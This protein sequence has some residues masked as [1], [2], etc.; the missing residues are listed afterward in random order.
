M[1]IRDRGMSAN[2]SIGEEE[3]DIS[4]KEM[5]LS[6]TIGIVL[7]VGLFVVLPLFAIGSVRDWFPNSSAFVAA[8][9]VMRI[10]ILVIYITVVS[11]IKQM[12]RV[13]EYHGAEHKTIHALESG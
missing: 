11:R 4:K 9:G 10:F 6:L 7:A 3:R 2:E 8:E 1:C 13:F 12:R 5:A